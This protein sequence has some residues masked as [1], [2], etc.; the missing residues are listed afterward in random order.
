MNIYVTFYFISVTP[1][2]QFTHDISSQVTVCALP[3]VA[4]P[5]DDVIT[6]DLVPE[7]AKQ[8]DVIPS[9]STEMGSSQTPLTDPATVK[10]AKTQ[11]KG[12]VAKKQYVS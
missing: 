11:A 3:N 9:T 5:A 4:V 1:V 8:D 10:S 2:V 7:G 6:L 12:R